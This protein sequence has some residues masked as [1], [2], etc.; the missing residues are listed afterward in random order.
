MNEALYLDGISHEIS[1][2]GKPK[3]TLAPISHSFDPGQLH[4]VSG[5][6]GAGKT[7]LLS[8]LALAVRPTHGRL[9]Y[10][11]RDLL[12]MSAAERT[13]WRRHHIGLMFQT[14]RLMG[15]MNAREHLRLSAALRGDPE[16]Y[17]YGM[18]LL[19]HFGLDDKLDYPPAALSGGEKQCVALAQL[20]SARPALV[21]ADEPTAAL[22]PADAQ[23]VAATLAGYAREQ[24]AI[25]LCVGDDH[26]I[27]GHADTLMTLAG[28]S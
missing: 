13:T 11:D 4:V 20:L 28:A 27:F 10:A 26:S 2:G 22:D 24:G 18:S 21:L 17:Q 8:I 15:Y 14:S 1:E 7:T 19:S 23:R 3:Q 6:P 9:L 5:P 12:A 16:A 25:V